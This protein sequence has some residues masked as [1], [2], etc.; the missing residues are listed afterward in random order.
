[1]P[2]DQPYVRA[3]V[4]RRLSFSGNFE[5]CS[6]LNVMKPGRENANFK[7]GWESIISC[8]AAPSAPCWQMTNINFAEGTAFSSV[9]A[10]GDMG[11][12]D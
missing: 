6:T 5:P 2:R 7:F 8:F 9:A 1:M 10:D 3:S 11:C 12:Q 4:D